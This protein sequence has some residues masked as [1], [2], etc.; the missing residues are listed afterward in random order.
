MARI[1]H[2]TYQRVRSIAKFETERIEATAEVSIIEDPKEVLRD[3]KMWVDEAL[4]RQSAQVDR[5]RPLCS[6]EAEDD[7]GF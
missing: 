2:V 7:Y 4:F 6:D 5:F 1:T 3:L